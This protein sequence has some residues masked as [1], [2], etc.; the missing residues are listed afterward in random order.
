MLCDPDAVSEP[1]TLT[2]LREDVASRFLRL[3]MIVLFLG[4]VAIVLASS[5]STASSR[6]R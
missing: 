1:R 4:G 6:L 2:A 5:A 3:V